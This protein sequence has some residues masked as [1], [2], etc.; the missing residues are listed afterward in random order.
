MMRDTLERFNIS[1]WKIATDLTTLHASNYFY[2]SL[3]FKSSM[4]P[5]HSR[6]TFV[7]GSNSSLFKYLCESASSIAE[8]CVFFMYFVPLWFGLLPNFPGD[9]CLEYYEGFEVVFTGD[10]WYF[11]FWSIFSIV[12]IALSRL[13]LA[14]WDYMKKL[15]FGIFHRN[16]AF[17]DKIYLH[18]LCFLHP[19]QGQ[20]LWRLLCL[21][22]Q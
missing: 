13:S 1:L 3:V 19:F 18:W 7:N 5:F 17:Y 15:H 14:R 22:C 2:Q 11:S 10:F 8:I 16:L 4:H 20:S 9:L 12:I 21:K 6:S